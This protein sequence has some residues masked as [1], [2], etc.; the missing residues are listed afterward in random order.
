[1]ISRRREG[2]RDHVG[3]WK[4]YRPGGE[5]DILQVDKQHNSSLIGAYSMTLSLTAGLAV[6]VNSRHLKRSPCELSSAGIAADSATV[7]SVLD[8]PNPRTV[9]WR[10]EPT[11]NMVRHP[12]SSFLCPPYYRWEIA[13]RRRE[14]RRACVNRISRMNKLDPTNSPTTLPPDAMALAGRYVSPARRSTPERRR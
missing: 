1:M 12:Q 14:R 7:A 8:V 5:L 4:W 6:R 9:L 2:A 13:E 3:S 10:R 11:P